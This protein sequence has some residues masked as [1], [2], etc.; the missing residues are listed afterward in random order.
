VTPPPLADVARRFN[1]AQRRRKESELGRITCRELVQGYIKRVQA[2]NGVCTKLLTAD[3][4]P[5]PDVPGVV[6]A[7]KPI[8]FPTET[9]PVSDVLPDVEQYAGLPLELGRMEPTVSDPTV[10]RAVTR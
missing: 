9:V 10:W 4:A 1:V 5:V 7:G 3:G 8:K 6:R 2:Y